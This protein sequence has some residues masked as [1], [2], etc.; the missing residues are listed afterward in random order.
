[1]LDKMRANPR[2]W[3]ISNVETLCNQVGLTCMA[4]RGGG[5]HFRV[6]SEHLQGILTIPAH[7]PIKPPYILNL[8]G[9]ADTHI[10]MCAKALESNNG[11]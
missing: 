8:V 9:L 6:S 4:P 10:K 5:S 11:K 1:M 3:K 7:R 2:D